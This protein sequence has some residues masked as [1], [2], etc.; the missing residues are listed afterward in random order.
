MINLVKICTELNNIQPTDKQTI[1]LRCVA[2][3]LKYLY[4]Q[5][6]EQL[7]SLIHELTIEFHSEDI[8]GAA[9]TLKRLNRCLKGNRE[10]L[11]YL[12]DEEC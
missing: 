2:D 3:K 1:L 7:D 9:Y 11:L 10:H 6:S 5:Q 8:S 12:L 4:K